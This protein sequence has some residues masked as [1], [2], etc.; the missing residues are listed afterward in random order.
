MWVVTTLALTVLASKARK[1]A[2]VQEVFVCANPQCGMRTCVACNRQKCV[3]VCVCVY[4]SLS[5]CLCVCVC[6]CVS[7]CVYILLSVCMKVHLCGR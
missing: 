4:M 3:C 1:V 6:V 5:V 7:L 2:R